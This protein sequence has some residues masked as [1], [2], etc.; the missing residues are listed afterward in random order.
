MQ[1]NDSEELQKVWKAQEERQNLRIK[2]KADE[3]ACLVQSRQKL[4]AFAHWSAVIVM[5]SLAVGFL[6]NVWSADQPWIRFGQ[7]WAFGLFAYVLG[8]ELEHG[9]GR[10]GV[11]EP[12]VRFLERQHEE[13]AKGYLR[14][15]R[16]LWLLMPSVAACWLGRGPLIA[17]RTR[18]LDPA[19]WLFRFCAGPLPFILVIAGLVLV[20]FAFGSAAAKARH[21]AEKIRASVAG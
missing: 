19:S 18:G 8:M 2:V 20:W 14:I 10:K 21:D 1:S 13:R 3:I 7:A 12:C 6:Y 17:A 9:G 4:N 16:R 11:N 5:G 15:R